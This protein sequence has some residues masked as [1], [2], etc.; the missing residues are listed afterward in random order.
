MSLAFRRR[1]LGPSSPVLYKDRIILTCDQEVT[2]S[3]IIALDKKTGKT[4]W[5]TDRDEVPA[6]S[7]P[8]VPFQRSPFRESGPSS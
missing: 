6:W 3:F 7:A 8:Y 4:I 2:G 5:Q 1:P